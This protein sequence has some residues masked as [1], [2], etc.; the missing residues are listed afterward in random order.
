MIET[1]ALAIIFGTFLLAGTVKGVIG[2]GLP[3]VSL[4]ILTVTFDLTI[5]MA[6]LIVPSLITNI[7]QAAV[8]GNG[9]ALLKRLWPFLL[10]ATLG[11]GIGGLG[12]SRLD[13]SWLSALLGVLLCAYA[14][15]GLSG[16]RL[17]ISTRNEARAGPLIG[18][19]NGILTGLTG[20][21]VVPG[22][23]YLQAI[24][25][26]RDQLVQAMGLLFTVSTLAL[27]VT[28]GGNGLLSF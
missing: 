28:L 18:A 19:I 14:I 16:F 4:A 12:L 9:A 1:A 22:V 13:L 27:A 5:A 7:W 10:T 6:L 25:L 20:S 8:G 24:G 26:P 15:S 17:D 23:M 2:L 21:F 11:V 3:T